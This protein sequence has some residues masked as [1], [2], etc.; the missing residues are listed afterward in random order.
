[1]KKFRLAWVGSPKGLDGPVKRGY[2]EKKKLVNS[3]LHKIGLEA[4]EKPVQWQS[5]SVEFTER[6]VS[7]EVV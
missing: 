7:F 4:G 6:H 2:L 3:L 5:N 1:M